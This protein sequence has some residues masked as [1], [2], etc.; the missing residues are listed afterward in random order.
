[1]SAPANASPTSNNGSRPPA[2]R[3]RNRG[4]TPSLLEPEEIGAIVGACR[5]SFQLAPDSEITLEANP[6][7]ATP[8][9]LKGFRSAGIN[10]LSF[11][12]Q[13]FSDAEL[14]RLSRQHSAARARDAF[15]MARQ[16][17]FDNISM[18]L[19]M[20]LPGQNHRTNNISPYWTAGVPIN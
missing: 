13:S 15:G 2:S 14:Q 20:W 7:S 6:E 19:M 16:A 4:G 8:E 11:G 5:E 1:M 18:D 12:V 10:R 17:G 9:R 3:D